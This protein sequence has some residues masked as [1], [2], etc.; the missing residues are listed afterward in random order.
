MLA[1][2]LCGCATPEQIAHGKRQ[3]QAQRQAQFAAV[4]INLRMQ[5]R[6]YGYQEGTDKFAECVERAS[7]DW[8]KR[9]KQAQMEREY[10]ERCYLG[11]TN[12]CEQKRATETLCTNDGFGNVRCRTER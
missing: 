8:L 2:S 1:L 6:N 7:N 11:V 3:E 10:R 5:C 12:I 9:A 4:M